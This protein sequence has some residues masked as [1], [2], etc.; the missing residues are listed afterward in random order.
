MSANAYAY[1]SIKSTPRKVTTG[2]NT[3]AGTSVSLKRKQKITK[4]LKHDVGVDF[5]L[6]Q[7]VK[8]TRNKLKMRDNDVII[9]SYPK[10]TC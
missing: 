5:I 8:K 6:T 4:H 9:V 7:S 2:M 10:S 3:K 1:R